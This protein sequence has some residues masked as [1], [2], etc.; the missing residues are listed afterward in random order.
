MGVVYLAF[1]NDIGIELGTANTLVYV[2]WGIVL[3]EH[4]LVAS[5]QEPTV[6]CV[7]EREGMLGRTR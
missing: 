2:G 5:S 1:L 7:G 4:R 3:R 6:A